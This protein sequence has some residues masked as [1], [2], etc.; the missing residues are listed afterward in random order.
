MVRERVD[1]KEIEAPAAKCRK[2]EGNSNKATVEVKRLVESLNNLKR[3]QHD[4]LH[5]EFRLVQAKVK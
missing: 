5:A 4:A 3:K 2:A 1:S